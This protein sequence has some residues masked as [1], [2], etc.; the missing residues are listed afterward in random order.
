MVEASQTG[1]PPTGLALMKLQRG[2]ARSPREELRQTVVMALTSCSDEDMPE[3]N[4]D[5]WCA[6]FSRHHLQCS[7]SVFRFRHS[8]QHIL[9]QCLLA[10]DEHICCMKNY[11]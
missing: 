3:L 8:G 4:M 5:D 2:V 11:I 10:C 1:F 6:S 9:G 7:G